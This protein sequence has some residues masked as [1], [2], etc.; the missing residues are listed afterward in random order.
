[1][2]IS[3]NSKLKAAFTWAGH[4]TP[5]V[6]L[7]LATHPPQFFAF[8]EGH[9]QPAVA[10]CDGAFDRDFAGHLPSYYSDCSR[11]GFGHARME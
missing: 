6:A 1:M 5:A 3:S 2:S 9:L 7:V 4:T 8:G 11:R 10:A